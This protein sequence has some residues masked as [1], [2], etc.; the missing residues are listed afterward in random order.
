[1]MS[2]EENRRLTETGPGTPA[3]EL[4]RRYWQP[5]ALARELPK[6][7]APLAVRILGEDLVLFRDDRDQIGLLGIHCSHRGTDLS[8]GR[9]ENGGLRCL[10]HGW[11]YDIGGR[12]LEQ[13]GEPG[14]GAE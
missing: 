4:L 11:L 2:Q 1:M 3:G 9:V 12:C 8:Y 10:Y 6:G 7:G 13:P 5:V 14:G